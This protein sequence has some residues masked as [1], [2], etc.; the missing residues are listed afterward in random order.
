MTVCLRCH[1]PLKAPTLTGLGPV[2]AKAA[3]PV[4]EVERDLFGYDI[5][6]AA[7]AAQARLTQFIDNQ[8]AL[9]CFQIR[10][11]FN[12]ARRRLGVWS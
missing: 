3:E 2:C 4:R 11:A 5:E 6:A 7:L 1:R 10:R 9:D 8:A 12:D